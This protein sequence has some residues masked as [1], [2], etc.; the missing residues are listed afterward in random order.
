M[1][2]AFQPPLP[3]SSPGP[4]SDPLAVW[5]K[6]RRRRVAEA[7]VEGL[8]F[9]F[10][11]RVSTEE[12]QD[13]VTSRQWQLDRAVPT[14]SGAGRITAEYSDVGL[15]RSLSW[16]MRPG[17]A[18]LL[19]ALADPNRGFDAVVIGSYERAFFGNQF[20][21]VAPLFA[22]AG[23]QLWMPEV[24]GRLDTRVDELDELM[25]LLG[26]LA[27]RE[28]I[29]SRHRAKN[30][31]TAQVR[32]QGRYVGGRVPYGYRLVDA[33]PPRTRPTPAGA[34]GCRS[35]PPTPTPRPPSHGSSRCAA[36]GTPPRG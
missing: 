14:I 4:V 3:D 18:A 16:Q 29:R 11:W 33:G 5:A 31:M 34:G 9:A 10:Y 1:P 25:E 23:V 26:I 30:A 19:A 22:A 12:H 27:K 32:T 17:A 7:T 8:R 35:S 24:G 20:S 28:V 15:T 13:P 6:S 36:K 2:F 21:L